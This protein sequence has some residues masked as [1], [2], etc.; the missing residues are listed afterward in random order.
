MC[1]LSYLC[2]CIRV[3][4]NTCILTFCITQTSMYLNNSYLHAI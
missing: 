1:I 4:L 3:Q 2:F